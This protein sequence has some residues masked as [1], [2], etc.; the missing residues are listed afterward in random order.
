MIYTIVATNDKGDSVELDLAN[1]WAGGIA[2]TGASGLGPADGTI[3]TVNFATSDGALFNSSRIKSRDIE[4]NLK[5]LGSDIEAVRH[6]LLRY[7][8]VKHPITLD[9]ITDY[10]HT[11]ITGHVEKNEIDIFSK[12]E[13]A[14]IT[15]V[16][17]NPFFR[18]RD[19]AKGKNSVR[20]TTSTPSFEFE[21]QDP[22]TDS[23]TL[24]FGEMSSTGETIVVYEGDAD[25]STV[26]DIQFLGPATGVKLYNTTTQTRINID[27]NEISRLL[28]ST[29]RAG[30]RL[31]ISSGVGDKYVRAYR[32]GKVYNALSAL[33]KDSDW[34]FLTPGDNLITV[35]A[36]TGIDN[37]SAIISFENL[38]ESI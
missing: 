9:F 12:N 23:P 13:G 3:N 26:V 32:D 33:D 10:R 8:R 2:V 16:C 21:F 24:I 11:Y 22:N 7:F 6:R 5:F 31:S 15:I 35:R 27:T 19:P 34:V 1:P 20:F 4:L 29:I 36:D 17:P 25:A 37:V 38:Y 28:G 30:D 18:L 14:D